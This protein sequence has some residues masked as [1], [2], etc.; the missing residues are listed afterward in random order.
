M[1]L[2]LLLSFHEPQSVSRS[3][4]VEPASIVSY[5]IFD[6]EVVVVVVVIVAIKGNSN[7]SYQDQ[8]REE[9][10]IRNYPC[11]LSYA[12]FVNFTSQYIIIMEEKVNTITR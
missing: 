11:S 1:V 2:L 7:N 5:L 6:V 3:F 12:F 8:D 10:D 9:V 4:A